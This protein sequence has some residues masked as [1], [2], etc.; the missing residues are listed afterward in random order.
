[1]LFLTKVSLRQTSQVQD[2]TSG[3]NFNLKKT[4]PK[5]SSHN[6]YSRKGKTPMLDVNSQTEI[7][8]LVDLDYW[9]GIKNMDLVPCWVG[10]S[11]VVFQLPAAVSAEQ[12]TQLG[13]FAKKH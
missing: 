7:Q 2:R 6:K 12:F 10:H 1:M 4:K 3:E 13:Y 9:L 5:H 11:P 8:L